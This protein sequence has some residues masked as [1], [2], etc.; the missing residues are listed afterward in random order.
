M[1]LDYENIEY[2]FL[3]LI[4]PGLILLYLMYRIWRKRAIK[5]YGDSKALSRNLPNSSARKGVI[6]SSFTFLTLFALTFALINPRLGY[7]KKNVERKGV[8]VVFAIDVSKSMLCEDAVPDRLRKAKQIVSEVISQLS[9]DRIGIIVYAGNAYPQLPVTSDYAVGKMLLDVIN[10][11]IVSTQGT[12]ISEALTMALSYFEA[13]DFKNQVL[14]V[15]SDGEDHEEDLDDAIQK[16]KENNINLFSIGIGTVHGGP[17]PERRGRALVGYKE[18]RAGNPVVTKLNKNV[19]QDIAHK[20][21]GKYVD[22]NYTR[23][24]V[25]EAIAL[26]NSQE[27]KGYEAREL[28]DY[29]DQFQWFIILALILLLFDALTGERKTVWI[30]K[31]N[32]F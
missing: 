14:F 16:L 6:K 3:S 15:L 32:P 27:K 26:I 19:L 25:K 22:G 13:S 28:T 31:L 2:A 21:G 12:A 29:K 9:T 17:I 11:D 23:Q 1:F 20:T 5:R 7:E 24:A 30:R 4:I 10:T 18:D 8:D